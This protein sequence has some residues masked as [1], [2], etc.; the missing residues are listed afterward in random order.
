MKYAINTGKRRNVSGRKKCSTEGTMPNFKGVQFLYGMLGVVSTLLAAVGLTG[1]T[2]SMVSW[3]IES[4][5]MCAIIFAFFA[6]LAGV[7]G[8]LMEG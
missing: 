6:F 3:D 8:Y 1:F 5:I 2:L 4:A 7:F